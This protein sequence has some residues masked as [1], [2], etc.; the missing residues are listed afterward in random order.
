MKMIFD[1]S[2]LEWRSFW[3]FQPIFNGN[4]RDGMWLGAT[5]AGMGH[6]YWASSNKTLTYTNWDKGQ[7]QNFTAQNKTGCVQMGLDEGKWNVL[8]CDFTTTSQTTMCEFLSNCTSEKLYMFL[9]KSTC[10]AGHNGVV[11][12]ALGSGD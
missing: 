10:K 12:R 11:D 2:T 5:D 6:F 3:G 1:Q 9:L 7:P 4:W 8:E